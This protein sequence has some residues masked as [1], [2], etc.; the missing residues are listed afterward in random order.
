MK[1]L[2]YGLYDEEDNVLGWYNRK[3][4]LA[5]LHEYKPYYDHRNLDCTLSLLRLGRIDGIKYK[6]KTYKVYTLEDVTPE[7]LMEKR[8]KNV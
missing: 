8:E 2:I 1:K 6:G 5:L 7:E 4:L 3:E